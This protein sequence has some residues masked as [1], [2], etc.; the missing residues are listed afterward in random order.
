MMDPRKHEATDPW[1]CRAVLAALTALLLSV[2]ACSDPATRA[3]AEA[4]A[5]KQRALAE[6]E[7]ARQRAEAARAEADLVRAQMAQREAQA[8]LADQEQRSKAAA[9]AE[10]QRRQDQR[11]SDLGHEAVGLVRQNASA[12]LNYAYPL[13]FGRLMPED[14][15]LVGVGGAA[16]GYVATVRLR[17][18][19]LLR[20]PQHLEIA[21]DY[22][23]RGGY[24]GWRVVHHS[25]AIAPREL[26]V[27]ALLQL[28]NK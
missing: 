4:E 10:G 27:S 12:I 2:G 20:Q 18:A 16:E 13:A 8:K 3:V 17:Y 7:A 21:F 1:L 24:K 11:R 19:N 25:D 5:G 22:D 6:A 9:E 14:A 23:E 28:A 26:T 15:E